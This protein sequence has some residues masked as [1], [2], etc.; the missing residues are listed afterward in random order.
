[1]QKGYPFSLRANSR[2]LIDQLDSELAA[3]PEHRV[4]IVY[5]EA[6]VMN[7][8]AAP[9]E[10]FP[11]RSIGPGGLE[12]L[13]K[14]FSSIDCRDAGTIGIGN[15]RFLHAEHVAKKRQ[16]IRNRLQRDANV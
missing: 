10:K 5:R 16:L 4:E 15:L 8:G 14:T 2:N 11:D 7:S 12:Q 13:D 1:M 9:R 3:P 6:D